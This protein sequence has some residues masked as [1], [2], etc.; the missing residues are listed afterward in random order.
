MRN[1]MSHSEKSRT[2]CFSLRSRDLR[3]LPVPRLERSPGGLSRTPPREQAV[4]APTTL[5]RSPARALL[6]LHQPSLTSTLTHSRQS[7][8]P[9]LN[10][11]QSA[12]FVQAFDGLLPSGGAEGRSTPARVETPARLSGIQS[13]LLMVA[14]CDC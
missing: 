14:D 9:L 1:P 12:R 5:T 7:D 11:P 4:R 3:L 6:S 10:L 2:L 8:E 13:V